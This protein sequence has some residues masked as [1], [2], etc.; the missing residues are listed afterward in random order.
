MASSTRPVHSQ[1][2][3]MKEI[4]TLDDPNELDEVRNVEGI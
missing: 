2:A 1:R 4:I 3:P